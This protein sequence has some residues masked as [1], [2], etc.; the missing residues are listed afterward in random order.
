[1][2]K[3]LQT[4]LGADEPLF[5]FGLQKLERSTGFSGVDVRLIAEINHKTHQ[6]MRRLKLDTTDTTGPEL[7]HALISSVKSGAFKLLLEDTDF[8][9]IA[10]NGQIISLNMI[11]IVEN[12]HHRL[13]FEN[14]ILEHGRRSLRGEIVVRYVN[15]S[16]TNEATTLEIAE[17]MGLLTADDECYN[18]FNH[19]QKQTGRETS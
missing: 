11:D 16:R 9:L 14:Q 1:M 7:Y 4:L 12:T 17:M 3:F 6:V 13:S 15:H 19:K 18:N 2:S 8:C 10:L 5:S